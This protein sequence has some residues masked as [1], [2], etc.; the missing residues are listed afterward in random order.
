MCES[1]KVRLLI[2]VISWSEEKKVAESCFLHKM[3]LPHL[4]TGLYLQKYY[5]IPPYCAVIQIAR[6]KTEWKHCKGRHNRF[7]LT[8]NQYIPVL[9]RT[10]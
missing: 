9:Y 1:L 4:L 8:K 7:P 2:K 5:F 10:F 6:H 3:K